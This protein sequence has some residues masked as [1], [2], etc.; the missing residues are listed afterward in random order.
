MS[1]LAESVVEEWLNRQGFFTIR[2]VKR[3]LSELDLVAVRCE[4]NG[5]VVAW[6][7]EVQVSFRPVGYV[8][9]PANARKRT[10][11]E[12][13]ASVEAWAKKKFLADSKRKLRE[14]LWPGAKWS[15]HFV[16]G[17]VRD[18]WELMLIRERGILLHPLDDVLESLCGA[19]PNHFSGSAGG[20]IAELVRFYENG[21]RDGLI[22]TC[23][24]DGFEI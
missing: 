20:D 16:H 24:S 11:D 23:E 13:A 22:P 5:K 15:L 1:K 14:Q 6:H 9:P 3:G 18:P 2:G 17:L 8:T 12:M 21:H 7:V 10:P 4:P 19:A